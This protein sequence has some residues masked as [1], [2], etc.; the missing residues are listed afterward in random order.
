[1]AVLVLEPFAVERSAAGRTADHESASPAVGGGAPEDPDLVALLDDFEAYL[2]GPGSLVYSI[3]SEAVTE[4]GARFRREAIVALVPGSDRPF[5]VFRWKQ[6]HLRSD[7]S[8]EDVQR[9]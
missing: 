2:A 1:M 9:D 6:G 4:A 5:R 8:G 7:E 3:S